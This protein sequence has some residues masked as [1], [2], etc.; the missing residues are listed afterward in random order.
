MKEGRGLNKQG[1][2][3]WIVR[4]GGSSTVVITLR[5]APRGSVA[6]T[7]GRLIEVPR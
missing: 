6:E 2:N 3:V 7:V 4:D 1:G 5:E